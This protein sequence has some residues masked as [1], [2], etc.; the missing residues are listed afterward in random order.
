MHRWVQV[1][2]HACAFSPF[3]SYMQSCHA[4]TITNM[5]TWVFPFALSC[6]YYISFI[7]QT[8]RNP[9]FFL[10]GVLLNSLSGTLHTHRIT[11]TLRFVPYSPCLLPSIL[12]IL[13]WFLNQDNDILSYTILNLSHYEN[14]YLIQSFGSM[15]LF[16]SSKLDIVLCFEI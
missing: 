8:F 15:S 1:E 7:S 5:H 14:N 2:T 6:T 16:I 3:M 10:L 4:C 11:L 13:R 9:N 12:F